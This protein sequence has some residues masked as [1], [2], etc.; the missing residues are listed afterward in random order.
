MTF[1]SAKNPLRRFRWVTAV[2][3]GGSTS[4]SSMLGTRDVDAHPR[5]FSARGVQLSV[6]MA[7]EA[8]ACRVRDCQTY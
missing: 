7:R 3:I 1:L 6:L 8:H 2:V 5:D 4:E